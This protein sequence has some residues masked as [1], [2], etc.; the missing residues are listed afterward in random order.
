M[1][2]SSVHIENFRSVR[3]ETFAFGDLTALV[4]PN[5]CGKSSV[6]RAIRAF[7]ETVQSLTVDDYYNRDANVPVKIAV[8]FKALTK[9]EAALFDSYIHQDSLTVT[10]VITPSAEKYHGTRRAHPGFQG[11][12]EIQNKTERRIAYNQLRGT[13]GYLDLLQA[14]TADQVEGAL[15]NWEAGHPDQCELMEDSGQFFGFRNVGQ[16]RLERFTRFVFV[17]AV[18]DAEQDAAD[19]KGSAIYQLMEMVVRSAIAQNKEF[20]EFKGNVQQRYA[21]LIAPTRLTELGSLSARLTRGLKVYVPTASVILDWQTAEQLDVPLPKA[22]VKL[23]EDA[24]QA[25]VDRVGHGLQR[26]FILSLLQELV[27]AQ[28]AAESQQNADDAGSTPSQAG[29]MLPAMILAI[30]EPELYQH[31]NRQR[32]LAKAF[33]SLSL[34]GIPG[35]AVA[36]QVIYSTHSPLF[37]DIEQFECVRRLSKCKCGEGL[38]KATR[39]TQHSLAQVAVAL[40]RAQDQPKAT[41][42][43]AESLKARMQALMTPWMNE[44]FFADVVVLVEG[45]TDRAAILGAATARGIDLESKGVAVIPCGG[46]ESIDR[47]LLVFRGLGI[48]TYVVF[49][50][51]VKC[52][53]DKQESTTRSNRALQRLLGVTDP[54]DFPETSV[55]ERYAVF[56]SELNTI[57]R[58]RV[59]EDIYVNK[60]WMEFEKERGYPKLTHAEKA[61]AF[62]ARILEEADS[63]GVKIGEL[64]AIV[65]ALLKHAQL[66]PTV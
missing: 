5:G 18:R 61:S 65:D 36:T 4:G 37:V 44:G 23:E 29:V 10:K 20:N 52:K 21:E 62:I 33:H 28:S 3:N 41:E 46:K 40:A 19:S 49:D 15:A 50:A 48:P 2:I 42:F 51:D 16:S 26:A 45:E 57:I 24:F 66:S 12:R 58:E 53:K 6:L 56:Q 11:I 13:E 30:E 1:Q 38:P 8:S 43:T 59:G 35:V 22:F 7:Y 34:G 64:D 47:P 54:K 9:E 25:S 63:K 17:P 60:I 27:G 32:F 14:K 55:N 31:P 39:V